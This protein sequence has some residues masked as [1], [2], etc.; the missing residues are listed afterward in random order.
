MP[1]VL[2]KGLA[3]RL[4]PDRIDGRDTQ[5]QE[6]ILLVDDVLLFGHHPVDPS[7]FLLIEVELEER[8]EVSNLVWDFHC[9]DLVVWAHV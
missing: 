1:S 9:L 6:A 5:L 2:K 4:H 8:L 3:D 7:H